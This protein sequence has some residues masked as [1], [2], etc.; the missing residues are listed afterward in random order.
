MTNYD[1]PKLLDDTVKTNLMK[2]CGYLYFSDINHPLASGYVVYV[3]RHNASVKLGRWIKSS[4]HVHHIDG[5]K[6]NNDLDNLEIL[7][8][9]EHTA[10]HAHENGHG[11]K[12]D[13]I[14]LGCNKK[15]TVFTSAD[16]RKYCSLECANKRTKPKKFEVSKEHLQNLLNNHTMV[17][18]GKMFGVS[19]NAVKKRCKSLGILP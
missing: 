1:T 19:G 9:S 2:Q 12:V 16:F 13:K 4:E 10:K 11:K 8:S 17:A 3:H 14:C 15:F 18:I 7:T 6:L 5:N